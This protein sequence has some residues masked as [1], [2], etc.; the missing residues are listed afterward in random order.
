MIEKVFQTIITSLIEKWDLHVQLKWPD[1]F[2][3]WKELSAVC[4]RTRKWR[5]KTIAFRIAENRSEWRREAAKLKSENR[6]RVITAA[7]KQDVTIIHWF[8]RQ[9]VAF[10]SD[11]CKQATSP[12]DK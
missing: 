8:I 11:D 12:T 4:F 6:I 7:D 1:R 2:A 9:P 5:S 3:E 10:W